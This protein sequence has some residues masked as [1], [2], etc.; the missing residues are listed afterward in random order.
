MKLGNRQ[1]IYLYLRRNIHP[2]LITYCILL[3]CIK[4]KQEINSLAQVPKQQIH[5]CLLHIPQPVKKDPHSPGPP[6]FSLLKPFQLSKIPLVDRDIAT[7]I[8]L[9]LQEWMWT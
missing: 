7:L 6:S 9:N 8:K 3:C 4:I 2:S 1:P 5:I